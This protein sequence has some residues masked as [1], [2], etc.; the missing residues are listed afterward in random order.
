MKNTIITC[1][2]SAFAIGIF[3]QAND[4]KATLKAPTASPDATLVQN[5]GESDITVTYGRPSARGRKIFGQLIPFDSLWRTGAND[6]TALALR[7]TVIIGGKKIPAGKYSLFSIPAQEEWTLILNRDATLHGAFGYDP[8]VDIHRFKVKPEATG[9]FYET[10]TIEFGD[11]NP[12]GESSL[13][14]MWENTMVKIPLQT[15]ADFN[16]MAEIQKRLIDKPEKNA[17]LLFQAAAYYYATKRDIQQAKTWV[18]AAE[19]MDDKTFSI[20]NLAQKIY[21]DLGDYSTALAAAQRALALA[22]KE[23]LSS[24]IKDLS[25]RIADLQKRASA[26]KER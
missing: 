9:R 2:L 19:K 10:F 1:L 3:A 21:A 17:D 15:I 14:L 26:G 4:T 6:C 20:P 5:F 12:R 18:E 22:E 25:K 24:S 13:N 8:Q 11:F 23:K 7:E 16:N